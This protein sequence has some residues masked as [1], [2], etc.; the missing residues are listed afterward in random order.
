ML[1]MSAIHK[2]VNLLIP[3]LVDV[4]V[5]FFLVFLVDATNE[6]VDCV[7]WSC[8][9]YP[10]NTPIYHFMVIKSEVVNLFLGIFF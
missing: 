6:N 1:K 4:V 9:E 3:L 7:W 10:Q 8:C 2:T 5:V